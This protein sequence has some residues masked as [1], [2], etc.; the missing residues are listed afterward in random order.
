[1]EGDP[2]PVATRVALSPA[3]FNAVSVSASASGILAYRGYAE[4]RQLSWVDRSGRPI[5][6]VGGPDVGQPGFGKLSP[7]GRT[8][9]LGRT[10]NGN[11]DIWL[12]DMERGVP[13]RFTFEAVRDRTPMWSPDGARIVF[14]SERTGVFDLYERAVDGPGTEKLLLASPEAKIVEDWSPDG[15]FILY[16]VQNPKTDRD[17]WVLPVT[18]GKPLPVAQTPSAEQVGR[19]SPDGRWVAYSSSETGQSE[20]YVQPFPGPGGKV[21][22]STG[23]MN[24]SGLIGGG[25]EWRRD[26][27]EFFYLG[28]NNRVM[29]VP[30]AI[31]GSTLKAGTPQALFTVATGGFLASADGQRFLVSTVTAPPAPITVVLNWAGLKK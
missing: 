27:R 6:L 20:I 15:R 5:A 26:G 29:A 23:V 28:L 25:A 3:N 13:R 19:F 10:V 9:A 21:Q 30:I 18:G 31:S 11:T 8:L 17:L 14:A 7:D 24:L 4:E 12:I 2:V 1:M 22:I 16:Q